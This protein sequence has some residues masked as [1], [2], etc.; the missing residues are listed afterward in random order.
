MLPGMLTTIN[1]AIPQP[2][3]LV[4]VRSRQYLVEDLTPPTV[5]ALISI[6]E[7]FKEA[8]LIPPTVRVSLK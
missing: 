8:C 1:K 4:W 5:K 6:L 7:L 2:G 3:S